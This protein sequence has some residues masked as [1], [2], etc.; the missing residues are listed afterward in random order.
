[1]RPGRGCKS[2]RKKHAK[3]ITE[4]GASA[5]V[6]CIDSGHVCDFEPRIRFKEV[7]HVDAAS[8]GPG[9][10]VE[11]SFEEDQVWVST[12]QPCKFIIEDVV[13]GT[14]W[15]TTE[16]A[17]DSTIAVNEGASRTALTTILED[18]DED[19]ANDTLQAG[20]TSEQQPYGDELRVNPDHAYIQLPE[21]NSHHSN[22]IDVP[23]SPSTFLW[24]PRKDTGIATTTLSPFTPALSDF[25]GDAILSPSDIAINQ[26]PR[27]NLTSKREAFLLHKYTNLLAPW[28]DIFDSRQH[29]K[30][31]VPRLC[32]HIPM[33]R[34]AVLALSARHQAIVTKG[35]ELEASYYH[36]KSLELVIDALSAPEETY[37]ETHLVTVAILRHY[38]ELGNDD[39]HRTHL[40]GTVRLLRTV[41][42]F[43]L[44]GGLGETASWWI[45]RQDI[46]V[47]LVH[48]QPLS[49]DLST[50]DQASA[51]DLED[52]G[53]YSNMVVLLV[54]RIL[55]L[56]HSPSHSTDI[57]AWE[58]L[59]TE[60]DAWWNAK[61]DTFQ[62]VFYEE[63]D[64]SQNRAFPT[65]C[66]VSSAP[67]AGLAY[68]H[69]AKVLISMH[70]PLSPKL[71][72]FHAAKTRQ[73]AE[74]NVI[75]HLSQAIGLSASNGELENA[76]FETHHLLYMC[77]YCLKHPAQREAAINFLTWSEDVTGWRTSNTVNMLKEQWKHL[78]AAE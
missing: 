3:C 16:L 35:T 63:P 11:L 31:L 44:S 1:M 76:T 37:D 56:L 62:P 2:C 28:A 19:I 57:S 71:S 74:K 30:R 8:K 51:F 10:R 68:Y 69:V 18:H 4:D 20:T 50:Y 6:R 41:S 70:K 67:M 66:M 7:K 14:E 77:G 26:T 72:G 40:L 45:L 32:L 22:T 33:M 59:E 42:K 65:M 58:T 43:S 29:C 48:K 53:S 61:P 17:G 9:V 38:E 47:A 60:T 5:C 55:Q 13:N 25:R 73:E 15:D 21:P 12:N 39:D 54:A 46:Y 75:H 49:V 27:T 64:L 23:Q 36:G 52:D 24:N 34:Y 78:D